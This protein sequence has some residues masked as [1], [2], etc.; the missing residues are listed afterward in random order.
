MK[1]VEKFKDS[2]YTDKSLVKHTSI[3][4]VKTENAW[5]QYIVNVLDGMEPEPIHTPSNITNEER[6]AIKELKNNKN[7]VIK[8]ADKTNVFV[9]M[10]T[11]FYRD[12]LV[13][14]D[15]LN[16][17]VYE[18]TTEHADKQVFNEQTKLI[19][20]HEK[21]LTIKERK[22][23]TNYE[24]KTSNFYVNPK[25]SKC[26]EIADRMK[27][28]NNR[29][30]KMHP[31]TSL[32][33][34]PI[35][36][37]PN[38]P[39]K[40]LSQLISKIL[41]PLVPLQDSYI[42]DD[43]AF[44]KQLPRN[45]NYDA[46][47]FTCDIVSL[48][49]SIP[50]DLGIEA[51]QYWLQ[52]YPDII[53]H[54]FTRDF[55]IESILFI[56]QNNNFYFDGKHYHQLEGTGMGVDFAGNYACL[57]IGYL[58]KVKLF[59][60]Y[61]PLYYTEDQI[62]MILEAFLRY[63]DDGFMFWPTLLDIDVFIS[64]L[65]KLH[66][67]IKYT[68]ERGVVKHNAESKSFLAVRVTLHNRR[69]V[70]TELYYKETNNHHY[71]E[72]SSFHAK[73]VKDNI[74]FNFFKKIIV[75]TSNPEKEKIELERMKNWLYKSGYPKF[76]VDKG[77]HNAKLQGPAPNPANKKDIIPFVTQNCSNYSCKMV[78]KK[79][80]LLIERCPDQGTKELFSSKEI[81]QAVR[82]PPNILRQLT[83]AKFDSE[84]LSLKSVGT[85]KCKHSGC[86]IC[87]LYLEECQTVIGSNGVTWQLQTRITC[88]SRNVIYFQTC[89]GC[90]SFT[91][92][93]KTNCLRDRTNNHISESKS[94]VT[95]DKFD[96]HVFECKK[97]HQEPVFK[98][99]VLM[100]VDSYDKLLIYEDFFSQTRL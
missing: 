88:K 24:W 31:P 51:I 83:S 42:K 29:Y 30:L 25:I 45:L 87:A 69:I 86:K 94:G 1:L 67:M 4:E 21:C 36:S 9:I 76:V 66:H 79:L 16:T 18:L 34:R 56:L 59:G 33:G 57:A 11:P 35:I 13:L 15:H 38:S 6:N 85:C 98:L 50:H 74:P 26:K 97:D 46:Q 48:Y 61:L 60:H 82:Q 10:D 54:R 100:E 22:Y 99:N 91:N 89:L 8:K 81:V 17:Q 39:T 27:T 41:A 65:K 52:E 95:T 53:P 58:E 40:H 78:T 7:I 92:V 84:R 64:I 90:G 23:I 75:F 62:K 96:K 32:K 2:N 3:S 5:L 70:E 14:Q 80:R 71:L 55:V 19:K 47:I 37:G 44:I 20:K 77:L 49:T 43:W 28:N 73:H 72:Y 63:V 12:K 93:G 68:V